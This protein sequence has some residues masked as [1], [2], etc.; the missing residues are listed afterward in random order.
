MFKSFEIDLKFASTLDWS[1][2]SYLG[3]MASAFSQRVINLES[4]S[5]KLPLASFLSTVS[6]VAEWHT[7]I[8]MMLCTFSQVVKI[9]FQHE[10][11]FI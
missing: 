4:T 1:L 9:Q 8:F 6:L 2:P 5:G 3:N 7:N 10:R 11:S